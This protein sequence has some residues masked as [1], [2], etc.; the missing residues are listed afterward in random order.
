M[1]N[2]LTAAQ[3]QGK[4][5]GQQCHDLRHVVLQHISDHPILVVEGN[6]TFEGKKTEGDINTQLNKGD[7]SC[8]FPGLY[9]YSWALQECLCVIYSLK[10]SLFISYRP[11]T[12]PLPQ[13]VSA[14]V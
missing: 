4:L 14:S 7:V 3:I 6:A 12:Q 13:S 10:H 2:F 9:F 11:F 1:G 8:A 5:H